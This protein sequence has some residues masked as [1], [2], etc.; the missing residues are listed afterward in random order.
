MNRHTLHA[1]DIDRLDAP[2]APRHALAWDIA[3]AL[4]L[5]ALMAVLAFA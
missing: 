4:A 1:L 3:A 5:A 2:Q